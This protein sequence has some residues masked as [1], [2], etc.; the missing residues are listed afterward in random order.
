MNKLKAMFT[1]N[2][3]LLAFVQAVNVLGDDFFNI[4]CMWVIYADSRSLFLSALVGATWHLTDALISPL[5]GI[6]ADRCDKRKVILFSNALAF[7]YTLSLV[8]LICALGHFPVWL[9]IASMIVLNILTSFVSPARRS[10]ILHITEKGHLQQVNGF[11]ASVT[12][13]SSVFSSALSGFVLSVAGAAVA[14]SFNSLSFLLVMA[15]F[16]F[17][18]WKQVSVRSAEEVK[19]SSVKQDFK[20][21]LS[22]LAQHP[23]L[24]RFI[25]LIFLM[26][27]TSFTGTFFSALVFENFGNR[28]YLFG[29]FQSVSI[30]GAVFGSLIF[31]GM[32][33]KKQ[34]L[35]FT[36]CLLFTGAGN[37]LIALSRSI[38]F[39]G[40]VLFVLPAVSTILGIAI[41][42]VCMKHMDKAYAGRVF[43]MM[44]TLGICGIPFST[45]LAGAL[46][47]RI[48][49]QS[50]YGLVGVFYAG[51][52]VL[53]YFVLKV[54]SASGETEAA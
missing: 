10:I 50:L 20:E 17:F 26:N 28:A 52:A 27:L 21:G 48:S 30:L 37:V 39:T 51:L 19:R 38:Y 1:R 6:A 35:T 33:L 53:A 14:V 7:F 8:G 49:V 40:V 4:T 18:N 46:G 44:K 2:V 41:D 34:R 23:V 22:Y 45:L 11:F 12:Q 32:K 15:G 36:L 31:M 29:A 43:G 24:K 25:L 42:T 3:L 54:L 5:A 9:A 47:S 13:L 16:L